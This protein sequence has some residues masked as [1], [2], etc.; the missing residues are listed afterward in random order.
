MVFVIKVALLFCRD[1]NS[2]ESS[3]K[4]V[5]WRVNARKNIIRNDTNVIEILT[6]YIYLVY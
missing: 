4:H 2:F 1:I 3:D 6:N 5:I